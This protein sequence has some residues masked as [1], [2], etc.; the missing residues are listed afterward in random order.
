MK[1]P[2]SCP[3][4]GSDRVV[5]I[6]YGMPTVE[7]QEKARRGELALGGCLAPPPGLHEWECLA[8]GHVWPPI[9]ERFGQP[10]DSIRFLG[11]RPDLAGPPPGNAPKRRA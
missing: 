1:P 4:C 11:P 6:L 3:N 8:C 7:A 10:A 2:D 9:P 5:R